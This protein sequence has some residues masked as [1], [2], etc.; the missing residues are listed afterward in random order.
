LIIGGI[1]D[2]RVTDWI[3]AERECLIALSFDVFMTDFR[4]NYLAEDWEEDT[5]CELLSMSQ[6]TN[7]FWDYTVAVQSKNAL[8]RGTT[9]HLPDDKLR[10]QIGAGMEVRLLKKVSSEK[11]NK[12]LDFCKWLNEVK[13]CDDVLHAE[14]EEYECIAKENRD[15]S[16]Q[17]NYASEPSFCRAPS[18]NNNS[19]QTAPFASTM[20]IPVARKQCLKLLDSERKQLNENEG[21]LKCR[22]FFVEHHTA[23]KPLKALDS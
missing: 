17:S 13:Q 21:C 23:D 19:S 12:I 5:L 1:L 10:H 9:S 7:S 11:L 22:R 4:Q 20:N 14:R 18:N 15:M 2:N 8:L 3:I 6:G 16:R